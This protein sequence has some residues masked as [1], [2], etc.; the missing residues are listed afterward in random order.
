MTDMANGVSEALIQTIIHCPCLLPLSYQIQP[1]SNT[2]LLL[3][4]LVDRQE[5]LYTG[6]MGVKEV[7]EVP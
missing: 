7:C 4:P 5:V 6:L 2:P 1:N 3:V